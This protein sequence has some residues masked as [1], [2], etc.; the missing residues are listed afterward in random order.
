MED[1]GGGESCRAAE[2]GAGKRKRRCK[3]ALKY[4]LWLFLLPVSSKSFL[5]FI[6]YSTNCTYS[7]LHNIQHKHFHCVLYSMFLKKEILFQSCVYVGVS[8]V[9]TCVGVF[10]PGGS[11]R[12][13]RLGW[14]SDCLRPAWSSPL[15]ASVLLLSGTLTLKH[16]LT[17][18]SS[19]TT[20]KVKAAHSITVEG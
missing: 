13:W 7:K 14:R 20:A 11:S 1:G 5:T 18:V 9:Y 6:F 10:S 17:T 15:S 12:L 19:T 3:V 8:A 2:E 16:A 4:P